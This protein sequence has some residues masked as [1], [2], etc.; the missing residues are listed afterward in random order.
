MDQAPTQEVEDLAEDRRAVGATVGQ[1]GGGGADAL[2]QTFPGILHDAQR[3]QR[4]PW[5]GHGA[6]KGSG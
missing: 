6:K 4:Q 2:A 5:E 3:T 1:G